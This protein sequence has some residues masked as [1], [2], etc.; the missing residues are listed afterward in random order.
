M[1]GLWLQKAEELRKYETVCYQICFSILNET[2]AAEQAAEHT[3]LDL[4]L[5]ERFW[6]LPD[7]KRRPHILRM[8]FGQ[9]V[10]VRTEAKSGEWRRK[11]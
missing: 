6:Q 1:T 7:H 4:A 9:C 11:G 8:A 3:L 2:V 5:D 10:A